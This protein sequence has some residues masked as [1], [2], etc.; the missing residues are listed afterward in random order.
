MRLVFL[1]LLATAL[2]FSSCKGGA[3]TGGFSIFQG[4]KH[5][6]PLFAMIDTTPHD[7]KFKSTYPWFL[8]ITTPLTNPTK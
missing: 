4:E 8:S 7:E 5:G 6:Y 2:F 3:A 1:S